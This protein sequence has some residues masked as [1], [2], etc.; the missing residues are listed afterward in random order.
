M[1]GETSEMKYF[2]VRRLDDLLMLVEEA[3]REK[4]M[5]KEDYKNKGL[6]NR[7]LFLKYFTIETYMNKYIR[8]IN[9]LIK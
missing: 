9:G 8:Q 3:I 1:S 5:S 4:E 7:Q 2:D 6:L